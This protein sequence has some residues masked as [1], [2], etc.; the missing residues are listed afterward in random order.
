MRAL[1]MVI[2]MAS[3]LACAGACAQAA[4]AAA[5]EPDTA[6]FVR[7]VRQFE[8]DPLGFD[9]RTDGAWLL[10]WVTESPDVSVTMCDPMGLLEA[11]ESDAQGALVMLELFGNAA[12]Q[13]E[14]AGAPVD[15]LARQLGGARS[16]LRG[17]AAIRQADPD[18]HI[19]AI[20]ALAAQEAAGTL[21]AH[22]APLVQEKCTK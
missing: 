9:G 1:T 11:P 5:A 16:A 21:E 19:A 14:H 18:V 8:A 2:A 17:Y 15:E 12:W 6:K 13:I 4:N 3:A 22:L 7:L 10:Q 20:D